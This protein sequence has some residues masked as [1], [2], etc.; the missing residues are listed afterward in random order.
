[1]DHDKPTNIF[2]VLL[3]HNITINSLLL[4]LQTVEKYY[5]SPNMPYICRTKRHFLGEPFCVAQWSHFTSIISFVF[6]FK[7]WLL[8]FFFILLFSYSQGQIFLPTARNTWSELHHQKSSC[9]LGVF[10]EPVGSLVVLLSADTLVVFQNEILGADCAPHLWVCWLT[11]DSWDS[12][13]SDDEY[14]IFLLRSNSH[15]NMVMSS[16]ILRF[17]FL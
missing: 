2:E 9:D 11:S 3:F 6:V 1:M 10:E 5:R 8:S 13:A 14:V 7:G 12:H 4:W 15:H 16:V 17:P